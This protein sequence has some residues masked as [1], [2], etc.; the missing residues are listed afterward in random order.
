MKLTIQKNKNK[1]ILKGDLVARKAKKLKKYFKAVLSNTNDTIVLNL[2]QLESIDKKAIKV[3]NRLHLLA[4][5][6]NK[7][8]QIIAIENSR[9]K[10]SILNSTLKFIVF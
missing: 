5:K 6:S 3:L 10:K 8:F 1:F 9:I 4:L 2:H 7:S